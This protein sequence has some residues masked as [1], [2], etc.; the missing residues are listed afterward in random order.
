V[1]KGEIA[2]IAWY[3]F[4]ILAVMYTAGFFGTP[5]YM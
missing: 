2:I 4:G 1:T 3:V 5:F